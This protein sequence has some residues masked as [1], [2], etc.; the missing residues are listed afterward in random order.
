M[1]RRGNE[2]GGCDGRRGKENALQKG[3][4]ETGR[5]R[6]EWRARRSVV[7]GGAK[8][9]FWIEV[10]SKMAAR[11]LICKATHH[12]TFVAESRRRS[13]TA[14]PRRTRPT[15]VRGQTRARRVS[16]S[17]R[18]AATMAITQSTSPQA[19]LTRDISAT[20]GVTLTPP[21]TW[22]TSSAR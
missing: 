2:A 21:R 22:T 14:M 4:Q 8:A 19:N 5:S 16:P 17:K 18:T 3:H 9:L 13:T 12:G 7:I 10:G 20:A 6:H 1:R 15:S 11:C